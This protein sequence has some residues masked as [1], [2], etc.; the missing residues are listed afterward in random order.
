[1]RNIPFFMTLRKPQ[2]S[3]V[4]ENNL[5][6]AA[7]SSRIYVQPQVIVHQIITNII[8]NMCNKTREI[9]P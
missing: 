6:L 3:G 7:N 1:L 4:L 5:S 8:A 9:R 2:I